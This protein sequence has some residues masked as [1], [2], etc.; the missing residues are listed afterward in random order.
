MERDNSRD[1]AAVQNLV[2]PLHKGSNK[3][4]QSP[5]VLSTRGDCSTYYNNNSDVINVWSDAD[6]YPMLPFCKQHITPR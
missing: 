4:E 5:A 1:G 3:E 6:S 2:S